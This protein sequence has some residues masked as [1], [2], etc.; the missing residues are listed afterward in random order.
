MST[1]DLLYTLIVCRQMVNRCKKNVKGRSRAGGVTAAIS[2]VMGGSG[3]GAAISPKIV[4]WKCNV[5]VLFL[6]HRKW[7]RR[8]ILRMLVEIMPAPIAD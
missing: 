1:S 3:K 6:V 2:E 7:M 8:R 4:D 5:V